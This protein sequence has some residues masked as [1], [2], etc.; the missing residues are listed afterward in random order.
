M[1]ERLASEPLMFPPG[2][3]WSYGISTDVVGYLVEVLSGKPFDVYLRTN[4]FEPLGMEHTGFSVAPD[5]A[6]RL[7]AL[8]ARTA[9]GLEPVDDPA[10]S[11]LLQPATYFSGAGGLV[12]TMGDYLRFA[13]M[14]LGNGSLGGTRVI[15]P[16]T[17]AHML[18]NHLPGNRTLSEHGGIPLGMSPGELNMDASGFGLGFSVRV[19]AGPGEVGSIGEYGWWGAFGT[20]FWVDPAEELSVIFLTQRQFGGTDGLLW[21]PVTPPIRPLVYGALT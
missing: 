14:L 3:C 6:D 12:S 18:A 19:H 20:V 4:V 11:P 10:T 8:Y 7:A 17:L 13:Q 2:T 5:D 15:G 9:D 1:I 21:G 16:R